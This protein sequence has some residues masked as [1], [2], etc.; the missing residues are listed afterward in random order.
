ALPPY[1]P[2]AD[3]EGLFDYYEAIAKATKLGLLIYSRDWVNPG[4]AFVQKL[5]NRLPTLV[6][7]KDGQADTR[8]YQRIMHQ[9]GDRLL[10]IGG[11]GDDAVPAYYSIGIRTYTSSIAT[12]SPKLS[13]Q[14][15]EQAAAGASVELGT[16][17]HDYVTPLYAF[18]ARRKGYEVSVMKACMDL[19]GLCG[20]PCSPPLP[21]CRPDEVKELRKIMA[22]WKPVL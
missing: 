12:I 15:H 17:M 11:A 13:L 6:A 21:N 4:P 20:G 22:R 19:L 2:N 1:F 10:W 8:R 14:L 9:V 5:A 18:R 3:E 7:W 16:L